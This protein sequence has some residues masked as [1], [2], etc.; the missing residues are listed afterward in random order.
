MSLNVHQR[1]FSWTFRVRSLKFWK[2]RKTTKHD[3]HR[4]L[5]HHLAKNRNEFMMARTEDA[6]D[7]FSDA[8]TGTHN[9]GRIYSSVYLT[10]PF[11]MRSFSRIYELV[12]LF[13]ATI[14]RKASLGTY[15][16]HGDNLIR[17]KLYLRATCPREAALEVLRQHLFNP[18]HSR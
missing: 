16:C 18:A 6:T 2:S 10:P 7:P 8:P 13:E 9:S 1:I 15:H 14:K 17:A 3:T 12:V 5:R 11:E 4:D